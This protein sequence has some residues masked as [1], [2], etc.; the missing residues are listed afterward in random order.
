MPR[1]LAQQVRADH[2]EAMAIWRDAQQ[3]IDFL[4]KRYEAILTEY[5][6]KLEDLDFETGA[7]KRAVKP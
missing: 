7:I 3:R 2:F 5:G 4:Q 6:I 1:E